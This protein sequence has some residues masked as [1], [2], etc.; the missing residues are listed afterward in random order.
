MSAIIRIKRSSTS[1]APSS[2]YTAELAY[3]YGTGSQSN[4]GDRLFIG[5]GDD[6]SGNATSIDI[7]G[8]KYFTDM[9]DHAGGTLTAS[10]AIIV[11]ADS[12]VDKLLTGNIQIND[13]ANTIGTS[14]GDLILDP[15]GDIDANSNTIKNLATPA[16]ATDAATKAYVDTQI[17]G[18]TLS[19]SADGD[20]IDVDLGDS[21]LTI[22]PQTA[23][24]V[25][26]VNGDITIDGTDTTVSIGLKDYGTRSGLTPAEYGSTTQ[27]PVLSVDRKGRV[28]AI[29]TSTISTSLSVAGDGA[30][31]AT[32]DLAS[33][34]LTFVG[35][36][37]ISTVAVDSADATTTN[38]TVTAA[39]ATAAASQGAGT[40]GVAEFSNANFTVSSGFVTITDGTITNDQL[41]GSIAASKILASD[42]GITF[43]GD[44]VGSSTDQVDLGQTLAFSGDGTISIETGDTDNQIDLAIRQA[45]TEAVGAASFD[46]ADFTVTGGHVTVKSGSI[47][48]ADINSDFDLTAKNVTAATPTQNTQ[49]AIKSYVDGKTFEVNGNSANL[50]GSV[51]LTS[52]DIAEG[53][54]NLYYTDARADSA[55]RVAH[56]V[57]TNA[58]SGNGSLAYDDATGT[59]TFTPADAASGVTAGTGV[60]VSDGEVSIGQ[61]VGTSDSVIFSGLFVQNDAVIDGNLTVNGTSTTINTSTLSV[62]DPIIMVGDGN[63]TSDTIDLGILGHYSDDAGVTKRHTGIIRDATDGLY[64]LFDNLDQEGLD[65]SVPDTVV[66]V[67]DASFRHAD[68]EVGNLTAE[69]LTG[70]YAGFDSDF[71]VSIGAASTADLSEDPSATTSS[72]TMYFTNARVLNAISAGDG[73]DIDGSGVISAE[74]ATETNAGVATFD[75][76]NFTVTAGDVT[77]QDINLSAGSGTASAT[78]GETFTIDGG[79]GITTTATG[80]T[81]TITGDNALADGSTKGIAAFNADHFN[82]TAGD[83]VIDLENMHITTGTDGNTAEGN[84]ASGNGFTFNG[85]ASRGITVNS[86]DGG[87]T[88]TFSAV[89]AD[90]DQKG[91]SSYD[92]DNFS[93]DAGFVSIS[94]IDGGTY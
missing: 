36:T 68:I 25:D 89:N 84:V 13:T 6:G 40:I 11:D 67:G 87:Q 51:T 66:N 33:D 20:N 47:V 93:V 55:A 26:A 91:V 3:S 39:T 42:R 54:N 74:L 46:S 19:I 1:N 35:G 16:N 73:I 83:G 85:N 94:A 70:S 78:L 44:T 50:N 77:A 34:T 57:T 86:V 38:V 12:K 21:D 31:S 53:S 17:G 64:H 79:T 30:T 75:G 28:S 52:N 71:S 8:G 63:E 88:L 72:G 76:T 59:F 18:S 58:A 69:T 32:T 4:N 23:N 56:S 60:T 65:S 80:T 14:S 29:T 37:G 48:G 2:L 15:T 45:T 81:L 22:E 10:S 90:F 92:S 27:I 9:L 61:A 62:T 82:T 5:T 43:S 41:D 7:I 49:V 24:A